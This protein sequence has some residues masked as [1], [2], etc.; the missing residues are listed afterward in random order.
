MTGGGTRV[1]LEHRNLERF[2][3]RAAAIAESLGNGWP[4]RLAEYARYADASF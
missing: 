2:G 1:T 4:P 3:D